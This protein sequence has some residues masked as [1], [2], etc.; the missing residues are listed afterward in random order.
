VMRKLATAQIQLFA[1]PSYL[2]RRGTPRTIEDALD[3]DWVVFRDRWPLRGLGLGKDARIIGDD[4]MFVRRVLC[5][6]GGLGP[7]PT[8]LARASVAAGEL[9]RVL[10]RYDSGGARFML[11]YAKA[12]K[13]PHKVSVFRDFLLEQLTTHAGWA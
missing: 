7:L 9:V 3:H 11:L 2:A 12:H 1:S 13:V 10:P 8:F 4:F 5:A 6:G